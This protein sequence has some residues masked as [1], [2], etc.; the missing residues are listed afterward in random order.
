MAS[1]DIDDAL[2]RNDEVLRQYRQK[3]EQHKAWL[4]G[5]RDMPSIAPPQEGDD[6]GG[7]EFSEEGEEAAAGSPQ[8]R[9][10]GGSAERPVHEQLLEKGRVYTQRKEALREA[11]IRR[12][13]RGMR[14]RPSISSAAASKHPTKPLPDR[15]QEREEDRQRRRAEARQLAEQ[16]EPRYSFRPHITKRAKLSAPMVQ[17]S[18]GNDPWRNKK[19]Q[20]LEEIKN[21]LRVAEIAEVRPAPHINERSERLVERRRRREEAL[22][23]P[24][25]GPQ[26]T[27]A[28]SLLERDR[29]SKLQL[30]EKY[31]QELLDQQPGNPKI[32]PFAA[33]I[34]RSHLGA[35]YDRLYDASFDREERKSQLARK[36]ACAEEAECYHTPRITS[37]AAAMRRGVPVEDDLLQ[38]AE[39]ARERKEETMRRVIESEREIHAPKINPVSD[40]IASR[41]AT[42]AR[43]RLFAMKPDFTESSRLNAAHLADTSASTAA[44]A[45]ATP[46]PARARG[47][48][49]RRSNSAPSTARRAKAVDES[50]YRRGERRKEQAAKRLDTLRRQSDLR[51]M[52][53]CTFAPATCE[54][55][56]RRVDP[57]D[58]VE[59]AGQWATRRQQ[60]L[61]QE[62]LKREE[63]ELSQCTFRPNRERPA[64]DAAAAPWKEPPATQL[65]G[66]EGKAWGFDEF[67]E[68]QRDARRRQLEKEEGAFATGKGWRNEVTIPREPVLGRTPGSARSPAI[69]RRFFRLRRPAESGSRAPPT[70]SA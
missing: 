29:L 46:R 55:S 12:E 18:S 19:E 36:Q 48:S 41:L 28:D 57:N 30:W 13:L 37:N 60:K 70:G 59:R 65:Y 66:G 17:T 21:R 39:R 27:H 45:G 49:S 58:V 23:G 33:A 9:G 69:R 16:D 31:Q 22:H 3:F 67:V 14:P 43:E 54:G 47:G 4:S 24:S 5:Q 7:G 63:R 32:T 44:G 52:E 1:P 11:A 64:P 15:F 6:S 35:A 68:R 25:R 40:E 53:E 51:A 26:Y 34:D 42:T 8:Q 61:D 10:R 50:F 20:R 62:R 2:A 38:R 56:A